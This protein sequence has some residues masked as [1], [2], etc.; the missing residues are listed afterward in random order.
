MAM[1]NV[2][3]VRIVMISFSFINFKIHTDTGGPLQ[4]KAADDCVYTII[5]VT[6]QGSN[7][8]GRSPGIYTRV[9]SQLD[10]IESKVWQ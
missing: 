9:S 6:S 8:C 1:K 3:E 4:V 10:W 2:V 5:G 7:F